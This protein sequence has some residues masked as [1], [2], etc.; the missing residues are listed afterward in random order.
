[1]VWV[2]IGV[3]GGVG[4][5]WSGGRVHGVAGEEEVGRVGDEARLNVPL[6]YQVLWDFVSR[7]CLYHDF[8]VV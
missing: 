7:P 3:E 1:M 2:G 4:G 5:D 6:C 8:H